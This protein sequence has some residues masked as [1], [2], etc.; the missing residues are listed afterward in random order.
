[1]VLADEDNFHHIDTFDRR[2]AITSD[3][4]FRD[5]GGDDESLWTPKQLESGKWACNHKCKDKTA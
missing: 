4:V 3:Q 2:S 5:T 1:M